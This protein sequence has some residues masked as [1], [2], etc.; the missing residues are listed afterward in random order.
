MINKNNRNNNILILLTC[1]LIG[2][3]F[4]ID[5]RYRINHIFA[6]ILMIVIFNKFKDCSFRKMVYYITIVFAIMGPGL[7]IP[8]S[9]NLIL[10]RFNVY[11]LF[12]GIY[13]LTVIIQLCTR[14]VKINFRE[15]FKKKINIISTLFMVYV[16]G[17][18][19]ITDN[20]IFALK[21]AFIYLVMFML[22]III[23][24]ENSTSNQRKDTFRIISY[25]SVG[26][27]F[28]GSFKIFTAM[29]IEPRSIYTDY[30]IIISESQAYM[31]RI[32]TVF[33]YNPNDYAMVVV[34]ILLGSLGKIIGNGIKN[35]RGYI[36]MYI[37]AQLNL[38]Y[39]CSRTGW[40]GLVV[41]I[42]ALGIY[43]IVKVNKDMFRNCVIM[44]TITMSIFIGL[45]Y[46]QF[47]QPYYGKIK[48]TCNEISMSIKPRE[49]YLV[50]LNDKIYRSLPNQNKG[51]YFFGFEIGEENSVNKRITLVYDVLKG[52]FKE[53]RYLGFG[54]G[55]TSQYI[56]QQNNTYGLY[57]VHNFWFEI[58]GDFGVVGFGLFITIYVYAFIKLI[59]RKIK[60]SIEDNMC[61]SILIAIIPLVFGPSSVV[62]FA[63]FWIALA[64]V[65][66][67][68]TYIRIE[69]EGKYEF[70]K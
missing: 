42:I 47:S 58:L 35:S 38:I 53:K 49:I 10:T 57:Y 70:N 36:L 18:I 52:I 29:P 27:I 14:E 60:K 17:S 22:F 54:V 23:V 46:F 34:L 26:I 1:I 44:F 33:F 68:I 41:S 45:S 65:Y 4:L 21:Q 69:K 31:K 7:S 50:S 25:I 59:I 61:I 5:E 39:T 37:I 30:N 3:L 16:F 6:I 67:N 11:Y 56:M 9:E 20:K 66:S 13:I 15:I 51:E 8:L 12:I 55:N 63:V 28:L 40:I 32:P 48:N 24:N 43:F 64:M 62:G 19:I 2:I